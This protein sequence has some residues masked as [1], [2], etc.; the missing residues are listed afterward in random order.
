M[1]EAAVEVFKIV[2]EERAAASEDCLNLNI[3]SGL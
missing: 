3:V 2:F 1:D